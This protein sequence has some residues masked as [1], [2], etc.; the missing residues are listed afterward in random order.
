PDGSRIARDENGK[1]ENY[2]SPPVSADMTPEQVKANSERWS[3]YRIDNGLNTVGPDGKEN[4]PRYS[5]AQNS[6]DLQMFGA[7]HDVQADE[8][9]LQAMQSGRL[10][11]WERANYWSA[12]AGFAAAA[13][14]GPTA[15]VTAAQAVFKT[16]GFNVSGPSE[17]NVRPRA[18]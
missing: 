12:A 2:Y 17:I 16:Y 10:G 1:V 6:P 8:A 7:K 3:Q 15:G 4:W 18:K 5:W 9:K 11:K 13:K 14:Y